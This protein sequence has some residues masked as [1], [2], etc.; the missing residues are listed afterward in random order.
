MRKRSLTVLMACDI[1]TLG[2]YNT[3]IGEGRTTSLTNFTKFNQ[4]RLLT[5][6]DGVSGCR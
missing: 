4:I 2:Q 1:V 5:A 6:P 3:A